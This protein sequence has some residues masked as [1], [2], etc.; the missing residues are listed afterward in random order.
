MTEERD[1]ELDPA[2]HNPSADLQDDLVYTVEYHCEEWAT[3]PRGEYRETVAVRLQR[4]V[5][6]LPWLFGALRPHIRDFLVSAVGIRPGQLSQKE[7][8]TVRIGTMGLTTVTPPVRFSSASTSS[9]PPPTWRTEMPEA[10]D[11]GE[12]E[13]QQV[14]RA[15]REDEL[16]WKPWLITE[17]ELSSA[18]PP[19][20]DHP[21]S[22]PRSDYSSP[23]SCLARMW[24]EGEEPVATEGQAEPTAAPKRKR[25]SRRCRAPPRPVLPS[26][27]PAISRTVFSEPDPF[28]AHVSPPG[29]AR[30]QL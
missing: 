27:E 3:L 25:R 22:P 7:L 12:E 4:M 26:T 9:P 5:S 17:E 23:A 24:S 11:F 8:E 10:S 29:A 20:I 2:A 19:Q 16:R 14:L 18:V 13:R 30:A 15:Y 28:P 6:G 1:H 21:P